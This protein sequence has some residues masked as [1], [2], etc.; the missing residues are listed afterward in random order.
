LSWPASDG[1]SDIFFSGQGFWKERLNLPTRYT[2]PLEESKLWPGCSNAEE[3]PTSTPFGEGDICEGTHC[4][5]KGP[6]LYTCDNTGT[7]SATHQSTES[8]ICGIHICDQRTGYVC[9]LFNSEC[10]RVPDTCS[11][12]YG[13]YNNSNAC[14]CGSIDCNA[15]SGLLCNSGLNQCS[16]D[17]FTLPGPPEYEGLACD[18]LNGIHESSFDCICGT[19]KCSIENGY[20]CNAAYNTC[21]HSEQECSYIY[22]ARANSEA[23]KCGVVN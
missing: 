7:T 9:N 13:K 14:K 12:I 8:C 4:I 11:Q 1:V 15:H 5:L 18:E 21:E 19:H 10:S 6:S 16:K 2:T 20:V 22:G 23:C 3:Q 17:I